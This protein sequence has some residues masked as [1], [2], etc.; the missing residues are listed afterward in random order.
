MNYVNC[1]EF[2]QIY[3]TY[4][5]STIAT[6]YNAHFALRLYR[7]HI[8]LDLILLPYRNSIKLIRTDSCLLSRRAELIQHQTG[9]EL[10]EQS[11]AISLQGC[12]QIC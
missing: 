2:H 3:G 6:L 12:L 5:W 7:S 10:L 11:K 1:S 8:S 4:L 9:K